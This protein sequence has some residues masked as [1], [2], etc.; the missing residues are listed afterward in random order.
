MPL[1]W[2]FWEPL[3]AF[4]KEWHLQQEAPYVG[5]IHLKKKK[6]LWVTYKG[7]WS[8]T[9]VSMSSTLLKL[10][11]ISVTH[12]FPPGSHFPELVSSHLVTLPDKL[13]K[14][15]LTGPKGQSFCLNWSWSHLGR[16]PKRHLMAFLSYLGTCWF[17]F[18]GN[19]LG[20][21]FWICC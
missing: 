16:N 20:R 17:G 21:Q 14:F 1:A 11:S 19:L 10:T 12:S 13:G 5:I 4:L 15:P 7:L 2:I 3:T 9:L 8:G 6:W 18:C